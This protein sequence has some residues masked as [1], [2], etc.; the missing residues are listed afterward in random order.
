MWYKAVAMWRSYHRP[1]AV[2][3][4]SGMT[5]MF[6]F[7]TVPAEVSNNFR[8]VR[9]AF[10]ELRKWK[11]AII[12]KLYRSSTLTVPWIPNRSY[13]MPVS[14]SRLPLSM[15][16]AQKR[17]CS[18]HPARIQPQFYTHYHSGA[19]NV[20][21]PVPTLKSTQSFNRAFTAGIQA[22]NRL[23]NASR[24]AQHIITALDQFGSLYFD[25]AGE[26]VDIETDPSHF[27]SRLV[28]AIHD[29]KRR[30]ILSSLY[31]GTGL[32][33]QHLVGLR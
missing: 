8:N 14:S 1:L 32:K 5:A 11:Q 9:L 29:A 33:E 17:F 20:S 10:F 2:S 4:T 6:F 15:L 30:V 25:I 28:N 13:Y 7:E 3:A 22:S 26:E 23:T 27:Y 21:H 24:V 12:I 16:I 19:E 31:V 18:R